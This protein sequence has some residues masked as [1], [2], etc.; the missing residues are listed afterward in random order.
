M[1]YFSELLGKADRVLR[2][3]YLETLSTEHN[4][5]FFGDE[6]GCGSIPFLQPQLNSN[7]HDRSG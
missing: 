4:D 6:I 2:I 5:W 7:Y 1:S 3:L